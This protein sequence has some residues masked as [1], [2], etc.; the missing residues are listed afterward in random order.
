MS[1]GTLAASALLPLFLV[2]C[3]PGGITVGDKA[4]TGI[5]DTDPGDTDTDTD[6]DDTGDT[7]PDDTDTGDTDDTGGPILPTYDWLVDCNGGGD[8]TTI[9]AAIEAATSGD[10]IALAPC[11]YH[12]RIDY[13]SKYLDIYGLEGSANTTIDGDYTGT[14]VNVENAESD[15][16][17]L[18]GVS[19]E[20]GIDG[21]Q[22][23]ALEVYYASLKL[24]DVVFAGNG[25]SFAV[26]H[27]NVAWVD[28]VDVVFEDNDIV[29]GGQ[30]IF[31]DGGI[32]TA[33]GLR[34]DCGAGDYAL[35]QH[36]ATLLLDTELTCDAGYGLLS[37]HGEIQVKRSRIE[38]GIAGIYAYDEEDTPSERAYVYNSAIG[39]GVEGARFEY[40]SVYV[41]NSVFWGADAGLALLANSTTSWMISSVF[42]GSACGISADVAHTASHNAFWGNTADTCGLTA[43]S[44]VTSDPGFASFPDDLSVDA[45]S[46][47]VNA[48]YPD[49]AWD[50]VD[51]T[52]NDIGL[53]G[54][55][56]AE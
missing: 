55:R 26:A 15:G 33:T 11:E 20:D 1:R 42:T 51:G 50:D 38:G 10:R 23:S 44:S 36:T 46:P 49:A 27:L 12:E 34:A 22:G 48:G 4:D 21:T 8:F 9:Q 13:I 17:R 41:A 5:G 30:A 45:S 16:T 47:L 29:A 2:A 43:T 7:D 31:A 53:G 28:M 19:I 32:L 54:G 3:E 40:M 14:V 6:V 35:W 56:W 37:Y 39:G 24:E 25:E 18:A 52:R